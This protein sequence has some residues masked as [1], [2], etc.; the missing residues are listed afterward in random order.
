MTLDVAMQ[1]FGFSVEDWPT[2]KEVNRRYREL[3]LKFHPDRGCQESTKDLTAKSSRLNQARDII[4]RAVG[5]SSGDNETSPSNSDPIQTRH[6]TLGFEVM[7]ADDRFAGA[8][9]SMSDA[10]GAHTRNLHDLFESPHEDQGL[11]PPSAFQA[12]DLASLP[13][14]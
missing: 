13:P 11:K 12:P 8:R 4:L 14:R 7:P 3:Q 5:L 2:T 10:S 9:Q 6:S 1:E